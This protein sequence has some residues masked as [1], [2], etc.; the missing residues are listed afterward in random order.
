[1]KQFAVQQKLTHYK[2]VFAKNIKGCYPKYFLKTLK[3]QQ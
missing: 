1:M 3:T 2:S